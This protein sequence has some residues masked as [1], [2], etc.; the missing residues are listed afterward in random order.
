MNKSTE[1]L[2][3]LFSEDLNPSDQFFHISV[4][5]RLAEINP[6]MTEDQAVRAEDISDKLCRFS[7]RKLSMLANDKNSK[8]SH[9]Q[10][11]QLELAMLGYKLIKEVDTD[12]SA[13]A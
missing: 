5:I 9:I 2:N 8:V 4:A 7:V 10:K 1:Q 12:L 6:L 11:Q 13:G 3:Q